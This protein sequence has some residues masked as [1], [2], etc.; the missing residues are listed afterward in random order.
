MTNN[1]QVLSTLATALYHKMQNPNLN[2]TRKANE[3]KICL[4]EAAGL[5]YQCAINELSKY[6]KTSPV[7]DVLK[8]ELEQLKQ[9][10]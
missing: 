1:N 3:I 2:D 5:G 8:A 10:I 6:G 7:Y 9:E 4:V